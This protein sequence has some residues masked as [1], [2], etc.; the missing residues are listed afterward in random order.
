MQKEKKCLMGICVIEGSGNISIHVKLLDTHRSWHRQVKRKN[1][2]NHIFFIHW[3]R[4]YKYSVLRLDLIH[5]HLAKNYYSYFYRLCCRTKF[6][7]SGNWLRA[8]EKS[9]SIIITVHD[10]SMRNRHANHAIIKMKIPILIEM[11]KNFLCKWYK[12]TMRSF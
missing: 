9:L 11:E 5:S 1:I 2:N 8:K 10:I 3:W 6:V 12:N 4:A 7:L